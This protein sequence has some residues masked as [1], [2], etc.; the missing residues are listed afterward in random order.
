MAWIGNIIDQATSEEVRPS[1]PE[2]RHDPTRQRPSRTAWRRSD[3][4]RGMSESSR[5]ETAPEAAFG[6]ATPYR[7]VTCG[8]LRGDDAGREVR[9]AG[10]VH[11]RRDHGGLIF[12]D[13]RDRYGHHAG[14]RQR[15]RGARGSRRRQ[16]RPQRIRP[17]DP[18]HR[19]PPAR[20]DRE[21]QAR[22]GRHRG[23][24]TLGCDPE[25][26]GDA[27]VLHQRTGCA[28]RRSGPAAIPLPRHPPPADA[29]T[30]CC[31]ARSWCGPSATRTIEPASSKSRR[32]S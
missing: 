11:R 16:P 18:R 27:A 20:R 22:H 32:R 19:R 30:G 31:S 3:T 2:A 10:W 28:G 25:R 23:P 4:M 7:D 17:R 1:A 5:P 26:G 24:G 14:R 13:L 21:C 29:A 6:L 12:I 9:I 8:E 15:S